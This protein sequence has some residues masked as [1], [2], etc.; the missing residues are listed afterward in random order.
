MP[1][2]L[3]VERWLRGWEWI[4]FLLWILAIL[5]L[6]ILPFSNYVGH[7]HWEYI[8][9]TPTVEDLQSPKYLVDI[10]I[11]LV[12]NTAVYYPLGYLIALIRRDSSR[13]YQLVLAACIGGSLS[14]GIEYYQVYCH[15]RFPSIFDVLTNLSGSLL[16]VKA[17]FSLHENSSAFL[18]ADITPTP[19]D[20]IPAP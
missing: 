11:D 9:W 1:L 4:A 2:H 6:G 7:S 17:R 13:K 14:L 3:S 12:A 19:P 5:A 18:R 20:R 8:K 10:L 15:N 16:G